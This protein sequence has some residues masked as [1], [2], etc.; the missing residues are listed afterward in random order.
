MTIL[1][2]RIEPTDNKK[3]F[4]GTW[5]MGSTG[6]NVQVVVKIPTPDDRITAELALL[7]YLLEEAEVSGENRAGNNLVIHCSAGAIKKLHQARSSKKELIPYA[8]FLRTHFIAARIVVDKKPLKIETPKP[9]K[10]IYLTGPLKYIVNSPQLG[11]VVI[12]HHVIDRYAQR[13]GASI[14]NARR[15]IVEMLKSGKMEKIK[16]KDRE[17]EKAILRHGKESVLYGYR[18]WHIRCIPKSRTT[19]LVTIYPTHR[20]Q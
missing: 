18:Y 19:D 15:R 14:E 8:H 1:H 2:T 11:P 6:G 16:E 5:A 12:S 7:H 17:R 3:I 4:H 13:A 9:D 20:L 10:Q